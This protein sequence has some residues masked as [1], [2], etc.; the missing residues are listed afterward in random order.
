MIS[1]YKTAFHAARTPLA[2]LALAV[3]AACIVQRPVA[4]SIRAGDLP[5]EVGSAVKAHLVDGS[6]IIYKNGVSLSA[7]T[8][9]GP[10]ARFAL[11]A[12]SSTDVSRM[13]LDSV[14]GMEVFTNDISVAGSVALTLVGIAG[15]VL[16][17]TVAA[18]AIFGSCPTFY[19]DRAGTELLQG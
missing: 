13:S 15:S 1:I 6:T 11:G 2:M 5:V 4:K 3:G 9:Q 14:V 17:G 19:A 7:N 16:L 10:G 8:L 18:G 12:T